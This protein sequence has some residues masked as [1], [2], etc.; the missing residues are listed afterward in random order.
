MA[1]EDWGREYVN[2]KVGVEPAQEDCNS[3]FLARERN[4][5]HNPIINAGAIVTADLI[6]GNSPTERLKRILELLCRYTGRE[7]ALNLPIY[8]SEKARG[9]R[10]RASAYLMRSFDLLGH[11]IEDSLDLYFQQGAIVVNSRDLATMA[12]TLANGGIN[13]VTG[14]KAIDEQYVQDVISVLLTCG[15]YDASGEWTYR[16]GIPTQSSTR[17]GTVAVVPQK[18]GLGIFSPLLDSKGNSVRGI[19]ICEHISQD[20]GFHLFNIY[21]QNQQMLNVNRGSPYLGAR[22]LGR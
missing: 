14:E 15:M 3:I 20:K 10:A 19:K 4:H 17:G 2:Q 5:P 22:S 18:L 16:V 1:L 12:A 8:L 9:D 7:L 21:E 13:P 11:R 6:K